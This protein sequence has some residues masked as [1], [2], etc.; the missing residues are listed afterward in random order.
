MKQEMTGIALAAAAL[1]VATG[2]S[3]AR[4]V[5]N[6][7]TGV[8]GAAANATTGTV[9][10]VAG[11]TTGTVGAV[12]GATTGTVGAVAGALPGAGFDR[13]LERD[14]IRFRVTCPNQGSL[15]QVTIAPSGLP[16]DARPVNVE[17]DG[18]VTGAEVADLDGDGSPEILVFANSAGSG[19]YGS[20][21]GYAVN[22]RKSMSQIFLPPIEG[23]SAIGKG[24]LGHDS[25][26]VVGNRLVR[27]F[28]IY[29]PKDANC[30]PSGGT[31]KV[32]YALARGEAGW[33]LRQV[34][35]SDS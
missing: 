9:G 21:V 26:K 11:A 29:R 23:N 2:C 33:I 28:P 24:Y 4:P 18:S 30:C 16:A 31:R 27:T 1:V 7:T 32:E 6:A 19:S 35:F 15:N 22:G 17:V 3:V 12:A 5:A 14:G 10:A 20:V 8:V 34:G 25:F 13:T